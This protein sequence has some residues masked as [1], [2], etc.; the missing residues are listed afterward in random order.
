MLTGWG[1]LRLRSKPPQG[2][3]PIGKVPKTHSGLPWEGP[4]DSFQAPVRQENEDPLLE[5]LNL[6]SRGVQE[7][8]CLN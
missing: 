6:V 3:E 7:N 2:S 8:P 4:Q 1:Q 5:N